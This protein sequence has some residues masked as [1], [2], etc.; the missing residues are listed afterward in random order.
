MS[1]KKAADYCEAVE[2]QFA[3]FSQL[4]MKTAVTTETHD[5]DDFGVCADHQSEQDETEE[6]VA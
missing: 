5:G 6:N 3:W 4:C 2:G 1:G